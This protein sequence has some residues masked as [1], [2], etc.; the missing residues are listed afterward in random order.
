M[1]TLT[2]VRHGQARPFERASD[3]LSPVGEAQARALGAFWIRNAV[4]FDS[5][6]TGSLARHKRTE[7]LAG[8]CYAEVGRAWPKPVVTGDLNEYDVTG[9]LNSLGP[10]LAR[11]DPQVRALYDTLEATGTGPERNRPFQKVF[12]AVMAPWIEGALEAE[13]VETWATF[14]GRVARAIRR[15]TEAAGSGKRVVA[16]T[17]GG[18]IGLAVQMSMR[19]PDRSA[20]EV[21][22][23]VRNCSLTEFIFSQDRFTLDMFNAIP[24][25]EHAELQTF[26]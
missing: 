24:H 8:M 4:S 2:L 25:L 22:W 16:F 19:A 14:R 21:N 11:R 6:Y 1:S 13:G 23:R 12:E 20:L 18:P 9:I 10:E 26:R 5:V 15:I 3:R 17:S 7:E